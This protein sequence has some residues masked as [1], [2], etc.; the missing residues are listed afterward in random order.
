MP[1]PNGH[2]GLPA[3]LSAIRVG[4]APADIRDRIAEEIPGPEDQ[5][6]LGTGVL[7]DL[8]RIETRPDRFRRLLRI[9]EGKVATAVRSRDLETARAWIVALT[10]DPVYPQEFAS[11]VAAAFENASRADLID[12]LI[13]WLVDSESMEDGTGLLAEWGGAVVTRI[14]AMM[15]V[16]EPPVS[17]R[18]LID[19]LGM[20]GRRD[21]RL[22][23]RHV[24]DHRWFIARNIAIALGRTG[25]LA[26]LPAL[27]SLLAHDDPRVRVEAL[28]GLAAVD[29]ESA[30]ADMVSAFHDPDRRVRQAA[31][32]LMRAS[33][34]A[35]VVPRL[36]ALVDSGRLGTVKTE[37]LVEVV[38]ER[39]DPAALETLRR[40]A[41]TRAR[42][43]VGKV[44]RQVARRE[45]KKKG[46]S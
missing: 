30:V 35:E 29:G 17:R 25:R 24:G 41:S 31:V 12:D 18:Y 15:A 36:A 26:A 20:V 42:F 6:A 1:E 40:W 43:G 4:P 33:G 44:A 32:S 22:L 19:L 10:R 2:A 45:L 37:R 46:A 27:K 5:L 11:D 7:R 16:D 34:S 28:R 38:A 39:K 14:V 13:V 8:L 21:S 3:E 23:S 9:W